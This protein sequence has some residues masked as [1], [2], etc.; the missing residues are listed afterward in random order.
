MRLKH[1]DGLPAILA[2]ANLALV[3][4]AG[5]SVWCRP[6]RMGIKPVWASS[7]ACPS[8]LLDLEPLLVALG[9]W[10][11]GLAAWWVVRRD[12]TI[13]FFVLYT[14]IGAGV[15]AAGNLSAMGDQMG[16]RLFY[17]LLGWFSPLA[18]HFHLK[19]LG[20][21]PGRAE[22][23]VRD[24]L[25]S[26]A[27]ALS[28]PF[29]LWRVAVLQQ[30]GWF[31][32]LRALVRLSAALA[33]VLA[34]T[35]LFRNYRRCASTVARRRIRLVTFGT[36][37]AFAPLLLL[38]LLPDTLGAPAHLPYEFTFPWLLLSPLAYVYSLFRHR[39]VRTEPAL[40]RA[41]TYYLLVT[42]LL[43]VYLAATAAMNR[44]I[45]SPTVQ[46]PLIS[47]FLNVGLLFL[48][49][50]LRRRL[51]RWMDWILYGGEISYATVV[52]RLA[53]SL[54]LTLD[55]GGLRRLL[56]DELASAM[57]L[58]RSALF[59]K[60]ENDTLT[61]VDA[62]GLEPYGTAACRLPGGG[63]LSAYLEAVGEP[64]TDTQV[65]RAL[66]GTALCADEQT[67][68]SLSDIAVWLPLD[69]GEELQGL[70][71]IGRRPGGDFFTAED[72]RILAT[73]SHQA[74]IA[75]HNVRLAEQLQAARR[76][77]AYAH[78]QLLVGHERERRRLAQE[79]HD[80]AV[81]QLMGISY[82]LVFKEGG[83]KNR[84]DRSKTGDEKEEI[85]REVLGVA[86]QLRRLIGELR[87]AGL[88][89]LGL[90]A[91]IEGY[92]AHLQR[93]GGSDVPEIRLNLDASGAALSEPVAICLFRV[94]Q[95]GL[96]NALKH[97][98]A[99]QVTLHLRLLGG[100]AVLSVYDD[101]RGFHVPSRLST[102]TEADHFGLVGMAERVNWA[103]GQFDVRSQPGVGTEVTARIPLNEKGRDDD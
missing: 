47:V 31:I 49:A 11:I 52:G 76:E 44:L 93:E 23:I 41:A 37:L 89:E 96:R 60:D 59:L 91:A 69:S 21:P 84:R 40:S 7:P 102:L 51:R 43:S 86:T 92:V 33:M 67:L 81:Q 19:L 80:G 39:L 42:L 22:S 13:R 48:F 3:V 66:D 63:R 90:T 98:R 28:L 94:A 74:G 61:L 103:G 30:R 57:H 5:V 29:L 73:V 75:A 64:V 78:Q 25:Y 45:T 24:V 87:P 53:E 77:L 18:F 1:K 97:A 88:E 10:M 38:S 58:S 68:L 35:L 99:R 101:G 9:L 50:P 83:R 82:Q 54:S 8:L 56:I 12:P 65:H 17:L 79:L 95:E 71:L 4:R 100:E 15:L 46:W 36:L 55:R 62:I 32:V 26:L 70:L 27:V 34:A 85:R 6:C 20:Q 2:L 16:G 72:E 14:Q